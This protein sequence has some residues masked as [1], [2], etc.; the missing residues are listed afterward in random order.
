MATGLWL[1]VQ[2][3]LM[4]MVNRGKGCISWECACSVVTIR[5]VIQG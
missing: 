3:K 2:K 4:A 1:S 5:G